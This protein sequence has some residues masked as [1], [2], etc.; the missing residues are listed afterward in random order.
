MFQYCHSIFG[1]I[2]RFKRCFAGAFVFSIAPLCFKFLD[3]G[4]IQQH[5][6]AEVCGRFRCID[7]T[8]EPVFIQKRDQ[9]GMVD[10]GM[11]KKEI[12]DIRSGYGDLL[13]FIGIPPLFHTAVQKDAF[14]AGFDIMAAAC[15]FVGG[16]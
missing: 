8:A 3:V 13:I 9:T 2:K 11:G 16:A 14:A 6:A 5:D 12:I 4:G 1:G 10:M 7:L 15:N